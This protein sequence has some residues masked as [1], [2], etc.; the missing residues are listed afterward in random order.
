MAMIFPGSWIPT[1]F[2]ASRPRYR[3]RNCQKRHDRKLLAT[4]AQPSLKT[5]RV[6]S[7]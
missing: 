5:I 4:V 1:W 2:I 3:S 6:D 7:C